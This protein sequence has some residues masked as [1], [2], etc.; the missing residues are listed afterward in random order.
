MIIHGNQRRRTTRCLSKET[1]C[2]APREGGAEAPFEKKRKEK[3]RQ[4]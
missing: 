4:A 2:G 3:K 1:T